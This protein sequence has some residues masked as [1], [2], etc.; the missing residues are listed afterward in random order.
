MSA[1][2]ECPCLDCAEEGFA[3]EME[4]ISRHIDGEKRSVPFWHCPRNPAHDHDEEPL[5]FTPTEE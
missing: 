4:Y 3:V 5:D 1:P 2:I